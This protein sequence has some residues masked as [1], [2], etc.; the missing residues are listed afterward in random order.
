[1][2]VERLSWDWKD[3]VNLQKLAEVIRQVTG[4]PVF[5]AEAE[6]EGDYFEIFVSDYHIPQ[7]KANALSRELSEE[8]DD[9]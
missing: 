6:T 9:E 1:M 2:R 5:I 4:S 7:D 3:T 8:S